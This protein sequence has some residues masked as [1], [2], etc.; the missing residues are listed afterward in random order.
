MSDAES[1][2]AT[3]AS[4]VSTGHC[5]CKAVRYEFTGKPRWVMH[6][7]CASCRRAAGSAVATYVGL[8]LAQF[9]WIGEP[10]RG[11]ASSPGVVRSFC[12]MCGTP[13]AYTGERWPTEIHLYHG[14][15]ADPA[16]WPPT[17]H[18]H[19]TEQLPWFEVH[20]RLPRYETVAGRGVAPLWT[21]PR[22]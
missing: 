7:H 21:G 3:G 16:A 1:G 4:V 11:Y 18:A 12:P 17:G 14:T 8:T 5:L 9:R 22:D 10:P 6:C 15:L 19:I 13:V 20:D 2:A